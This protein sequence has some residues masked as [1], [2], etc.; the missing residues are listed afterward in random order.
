MR[1]CDEAL[2]SRI[3]QALDRSE[4]PLIGAVGI[5]VRDRE[6]AESFAARLTADHVRHAAAIR[7]EPPE[8]RAT[9]AQDREDLI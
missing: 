9:G 5:A 2:A 7:D 8:L 6:Q 3:V 4:Q 1:G